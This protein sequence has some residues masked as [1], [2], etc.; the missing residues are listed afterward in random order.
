MLKTN[1]FW[2]FSW[3]L[4]VSEIADSGWT[5][6]FAFISYLWYLLLAFL[7]LYLGP[8]SWWIISNMTLDRKNLLFRRPSLPLICIRQ[9][10]VHG[11]MDLRKIMTTK[12]RQWGF[13]PHLT[14][15]PLLYVPVIIT[16][17]HTFLFLVTGPHCFAQTD[18]KTL[19]I[20]LSYPLECWDL[21]NVYLLTE[22][23]AQGH[24]RHSLVFELL[25]VLSRNRS[26]LGFP[27]APFINNRIMCTQS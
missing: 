11:T 20:L 19:P 18:L 26:K 4:G 23:W 15:F 12:R 10:T 1:F 21:E 22:F 9:L 2:S 8:G 25:R 16:E 17:A 3:Q 7:Y 14:V 27:P 13:W 24:A 6:F 5:M